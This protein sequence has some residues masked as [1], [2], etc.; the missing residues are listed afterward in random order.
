MPRYAFLARSRAGAA[1]RGLRLADSPGALAPVL[2]A[3]GLFLVRAEAAAPARAQ[4]KAGPGDLP[5]LLHHLATYLEAG[6]PLLTALRDFRDPGRPR[7]EAAALDLAARVEEGA[8]FSAAMAAHP[9]LFLP[10]HVGM[11]RAGEA[12][13]RL[14]EA[15][16]AVI[17]LVDWRIAFR[18]RVRKAATYPLIL[19]AVLAVVILLISIFSLPPI[20]R[21]LEDL[22]I[23]LPRVTRALLALGRG[24]G[25]FGWVAVAVPAALRGGLALALRRPGFRLAWDTALLRVPVVGRLIARMAL[26]RFAHFLAAQHRAGLP[27]VQALRACEEVTGNAR[28]RLAVR[29]MRSGVEQG[30]GLA[31]SAAGTGQVPQLVLRML[32]LGEE[33]GHLGET[34]DR[35][36]AHLDAEVD[37][38]VGLAFQLVDPAVKILMACLLLFLATAVL[39]PLYTLIGGINA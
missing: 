17:S 16:H 10:V 25:R 5:P 24:L 22:D 26:S 28:M 34:L 21:L 14:D 39:L 2:A 3:E 35:A 20:L 31:A 4:G 23:P 36:A 29:A 11:V 1:V 37:E 38:A 32:A 33:T 30:R 27:L 15:L 12:A 7:L 13:G 6:I 18:A 19:A 9:G 8:A